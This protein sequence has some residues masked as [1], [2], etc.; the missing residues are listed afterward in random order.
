MSMW[1]V[2]R[3]LGALA[4]LAEN[5]VRADHCVAHLDPSVIQSGDTVVGVLP[6]PL[7]AEVCQRGARYFHL[8]L[9]LSADWRGRELTA[10]DMDGCGAH[11]KEF[12]LLAVPGASA[13]D[14]IRS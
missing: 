5:G 1:L 13:L 12:V 10:R 8:C 14:V 4:W 3:H 11:L 6:L 9:T 7:A 2:T